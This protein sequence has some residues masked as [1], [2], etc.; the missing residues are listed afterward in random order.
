MDNYDDSP[1]RTTSS[2]KGIFVGADLCV[3]PQNRSFLLKR[4]V[5]RKTMISYQ[6]E[7]TQVLPCNIK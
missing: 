3:R 1:I 7:H 6:R 4:L 2:T 5:N